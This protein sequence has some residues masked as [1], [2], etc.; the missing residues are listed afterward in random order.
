MTV[1]NDK[2]TFKEFMTDL[3]DKTAKTKNATKM[4][5]EKKNEIQSLP[6]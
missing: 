1:M 6:L 3:K 5:E 4:A 2:K